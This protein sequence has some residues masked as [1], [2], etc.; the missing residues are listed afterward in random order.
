[1]KQIAIVGAGFSG[2]AVAWNLLQRLA[3]LAR[4]IL[5]DKEPGVGRG[6]AFGAPSPHHLLNV[7]AGR[8]GLNPGDEG[9][10]LRYLQQIGLPFQSGDFAPRSLYGSY[11]EHS[12]GEQRAAAADHGV[13]LH[14]QRGVVEGIEPMGAGRHMLRLSDGQHFEVDVVVLALGNFSPRPPEIANGPNWEAPGLHATPWSLR[15]INSLPPRAPV[16][17]IGSGLTAFDV[18]L[19][20]RHEGH[21]GVVTMLS[22]RGLLAQSH[23]R[24]ESAP[25]QGLVPHDFLDGMQTVSAMLRETRQLIRQARAIGHDWRDVVGGLRQIT[26]RLWQQLPTPE[27]QRFLRHLL[28]YWDTHRHR[29][30]VPIASAISHEIE[31]QALQPMAGRLESLVA[32]G[33][34]W[35]ASIQLRGTAKMHVWKGSAVINCS[36]PSSSLRAAKHDHLIQSLLAKG[37]ILPDALSLGVSV[38]TQYRLLDGQGRGQ[39]GLFYLGPMLK[40]QFWE[41]TAVPELRSHAQ[42]V[43]DAVV[44]YCQALCTA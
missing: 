12:L 13:E 40:A 36:G 11:L 14:I 18:V 22:R 6:L 25:A 21:R 16:L 38:D 35:E 39:D 44:G 42:R 37:K 7:P 20:L 32:D 1:M 17:L 24:L 2:V 28:P 33:T 8:M 15:G 31:A 26:V 5:I 41:A 9:G 30:A 4:V 23:R 43:S 19:Q 3:G 10:F 27:R 29:A 34:E